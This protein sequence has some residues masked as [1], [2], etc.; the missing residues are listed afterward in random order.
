[1]YAMF[2]ALE[3]FDQ[4]RSLM[5]SYHRQTSRAVISLAYA[6]SVGTSAS[7]RSSCQNLVVA[8]RRKRQ[9]TRMRMTSLFPVSTKIEAHPRK[10]ESRLSLSQMPEHSFPVR[11]GFSN[12][13]PPFERG[14][15]LVSTFVSVV[16][17]VKPLYAFLETKSGMPDNF[18]SALHDE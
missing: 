6:Q 15:D 1:M 5:Q 9:D 10:R 17:T 12:K 11:F 3:R 2:E 8:L 4:H 7:G 13:N 18:R 14:N 16:S